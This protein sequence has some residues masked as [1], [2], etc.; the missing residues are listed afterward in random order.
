VDVKAVA[1]QFQTSID[2]PV[3]HC[4]HGSVHASFQSTKL[5][6]GNAFRIDNSYCF[7]DS[8][9]TNGKSLRSKFGAHANR[10]HAFAVSIRASP[11]DFL[12]LLQEFSIGQTTPDLCLTATLIQR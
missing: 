6:S 3:L 5:S 9:D 12:G 1:G 11:L 10:A 7:A 8:I 4:A 2:V